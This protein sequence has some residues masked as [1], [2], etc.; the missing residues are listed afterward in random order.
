MINNNL[1]ESLAS[2]NENEI[3]IWSWNNPSEEFYFVALKGVFLESVPWFFV[4]NKKL[5]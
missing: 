5:T 1:C 2:R 3:I 4:V